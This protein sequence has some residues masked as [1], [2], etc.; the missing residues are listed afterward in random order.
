MRRK[1]SDASGPRVAKTLG[2]CVELR[3]D[4]EDIKLDVMK[5]FVTKKF[6][7]STDLRTRLI[8]TGD[9]ELIEGNPWRDQFWGVYTG[10]GENHL[11]KILMQVRAAINKG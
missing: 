6:T 3:P 5:L 10:I 4:W 8:A 9:A 7:E 11:G 2:R 1:I